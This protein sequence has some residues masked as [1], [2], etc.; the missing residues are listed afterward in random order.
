MITKLPGL[1][2]LDDR[3]VFKD[4]RRNA[5]AFSRGGLDE[6]RAERE[7]IKE[8]KRAKDEANRVAFKDMIKQARAEKK[9]ADEEKAAIDEEIAVAEAAA[10]AAA[11][12]N[13]PADEEE[14]EEEEEECKDEE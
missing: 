14:D 8:E 5:E 2:Y 11:A 13:A 1:K 12:A 4:D 3:P 9:L 6:E 10:E 7:L